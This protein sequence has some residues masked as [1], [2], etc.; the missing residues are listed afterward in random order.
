M[1]TT[2][3]RDPVRKPQ[4]EDE[5]RRD[6]YGNRVYVQREQ[7]PPRSPSASPPPL[8][9]P[10]VKPR[11]GSGVGIRSLAVALGALALA[12]AGLT[13]V[14]LRSPAV[15]AA[16][17]SDQSAHIDHAWSGVQIR[18]NGRG[19]ILEVSG[20]DPRMVLRGYCEPWPSARLCEPLEIRSASSGAAGQRLG[21][22]RD[23]EWVGL[24]SI[25]IVRSE[26]SHLWV[27]GGREEPIA[28]S[29]ADDPPPGAMSVPIQGTK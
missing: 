9:V 20:P 4:A 25:A 5:C 13:A 14:L 3:D 24:R 15:E 11:A 27:A 6:A 12:L 21:I 7:R 19:E 18:S 29:M 28:V 8:P 10:Q 17:A 26:S 22:L 23:P 16:V 1:T 2:I